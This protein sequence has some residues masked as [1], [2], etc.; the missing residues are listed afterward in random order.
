[1]KFYDRNTGIYIAD[2][3]EDLLACT[4][5]S[6]DEIKALLSGY[7]LSVSGWRAVFARSKDENDH[8]SDV[9]DGDRIIAAAAASAFFSYLGK[10]HPRI[11]LGSDT[12]PT[13]RMLT[14]IAARILI[15]LGADVD[16]L[17]IASA[18]EIMAYSG[19]G[20]DGFLYVSA[21][22]NPIGHNGFK[23]G[24]RGGVLESAE[25]EK[26]KSIFLSHMDD[27]IAERMRTFSA[28]VSEE[29][30]RTVL[31]HH[32]TVKRRSLRY[33]ASF[34]LH[35]AHADDDAMIP[36]GIVVDFN[37]SARSASI[38]IPFL[39]SHGADV[40]ALNS[41]PGQ[42]VHGIIPEGSNLDDARK[43]LE[44]AYRRNPRFI[45]GYVPDNDGDRGNFVYIART[46][47]AC[48]L[49]AQEGFA[50]VS[51]IEL[52]HA[53]MMHPGRKA[54]IA[55]NGPTSLLLDDIASR[56]GVEVFR[57]DIGEANV[58]SLADRLRSEGYSVPICGE[59][60]NGGCIVYP[61]KVR[62]PMNSLMAIAKLW[63]VPGLYGFLMKALGKK[64]RAVS[65]D[66]VLSAFPEYLM[67]PSSSPD[68]VLGIRSRDWPMM[69]RE[70]VRIAEAEAAANMPEGAVRYEIREYE[71]S[72]EIVSP[73]AAGTPTG[74][75]KLQFLSA[76][77]SPVAYIWLSRSR[78]E[79]VCRIMACVKG[80]NAA[81]HDHLLAWLRSMEERA[82]RVVF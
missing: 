4:A 45:L 56:L 64:G 2:S 70:Y 68:A 60:S 58:V 25:E 23:F 5:A 62:D 76:D 43:A 27:G 21:S 34:V 69:K 41:V 78:T 66:A 55:V 48:A 16:F 80:R 53:V 22:H 6:Y 75:V 7:I 73:Y 79:P 38:D 61:A 15:A 29:S 12:R 32:E 36:F 71:G 26:V 30:Y 11:L 13:G 44:K 33:Y 47:K 19:S 52:A 17:G 74:G 8:S 20:Y 49:S 40:L 39:R 59:G 67:T 77:S 65:I 1:M 31:K 35:T 81:V 18:P 37:G 28:S 50:L 72:D 63:S 14:A 51:S 54:A 57:S 82:D 10:D 3:N 42:I 46:G 24:M 9:G